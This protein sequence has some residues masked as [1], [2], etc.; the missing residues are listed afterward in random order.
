MEFFHDHARIE[1]IFFDGFREP[2]D[3]CM[4]PDLSRP[5]M[6]LELKENDVTQ[7]RK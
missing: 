7:F 2:V 1:R 6:G 5:G 3:G 4:I